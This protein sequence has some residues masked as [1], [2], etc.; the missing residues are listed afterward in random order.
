MEHKGFAGV[1]FFTRDDQLAANRSMR[2]FMDPQSGKYM[3]RNLHLAQEKDLD[4]FTKRDN[5]RKYR[6]EPVYHHQQQQPQPQLQQQQ[7]PPPTRHQMM[8]NF[9][10][11]MQPP[12]QPQFFD[13][14]IAAL[15]LPPPDLLNFKYAGELK[16][17]I[18][19]RPIFIVG[20]EW[21]CS[22][23][24]PIEIGIST[25]S[26]AAESVQTFHKF[27][28]PG[29]LP[30]PLVGDAFFSER[31]VHGISQAQLRQNGDVKFP[32]LFRELFQFTQCREPIVYA[33]GPY[34]VVETIKWIAERAGA[35]NAAQSWKV[36]EVEEL[37]GL[38]HTAYGVP[39]K[40]SACG[41][42]FIKDHHVPPEMKCHYH[43]D[44]DKDKRCV[45]GDVRKIAVFLKN[46][47]K[48]LERGH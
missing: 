21:A 45:L 38:L 47:V 33:R 32:V 36:R 35:P 31:R 29:H 34:K 42:I 16:S 40:T 41:D 25:L 18:L 37:V 24:T 10:P 20:V 14:A 15:P 7:Q 1:E 27:I 6:D 28:E 48:T 13:P 19:S 4:W 3:W 44:K 30:E 11:P 8:P 12:P 43:K 22:V 5:K 17:A 26:I 2:D 39:I 23:C 9:M 46:L